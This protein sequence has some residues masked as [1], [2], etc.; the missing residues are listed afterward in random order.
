MMVKQQLVAEIELIDN[1]FN[2][3]ESEWRKTVG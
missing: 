3:I 1:E 2:K